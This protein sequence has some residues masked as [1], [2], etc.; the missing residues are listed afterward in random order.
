MQDIMSCSFSI[1]PSLLL[2]APGIKLTKLWKTDAD[3]RYT[4]M[5]SS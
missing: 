3:T 4:V 2:F 1:D 5:Q